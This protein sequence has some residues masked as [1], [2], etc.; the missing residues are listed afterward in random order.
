MDGENKKSSI[1]D[2]FKKNHFNIIF[3]II[4]GVGGYL[5]WSNTKPQ[6]PKSIEELI[7]TIKENAKTVTTQ[8]HS[9]EKTKVEQE[10]KDASPSYYFKPFGISSVDSIKTT[11]ESSKEEEVP[12]C[13][14][15]R[16]D[17]FENALKAVAL[18]SR[19]EAAEDYHKSFSI[20]VAMLALFGIGFPILVA[21]MQH[22]F[23]ERQLNKIEE[24]SKAV[25]ESKKQAD[26]ALGQV[27]DVAKKNENNLKQINSL[28]EKNEKIM[29]DQHND[30]ILINNGL[31]ILFH[32]PVYN[33]SIVWECYFM[34]KTIFHSLE[35]FKFTN[36]KNY[37]QLNYITSF[38]N[39]YLDFFN[40]EDIQ[41]LNQKDDITYM[42]INIQ[43]QLV[44]FIKTLTSIL[45]DLEKEDLKQDINNL[46]NDLKKKKEKIEEIKKQFFK[47]NKQVNLR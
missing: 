33:N 1:I 30:L 45:Q 21:F 18:V 22:H 11:I 39:N 37:T 26:E 13:Y 16:L 14:T 36:P 32:N 44:F 31:S 38:L 35:G 23:N 42:Y 10:F 46:K 34:G 6:E 40:K 20:F 4:F 41:K 7:K 24:T 8:R 43:T 3:A 12:E 29:F 28:L 9:K 15:I 27:N 19:Q 17:D 5:L 47:D 2:W 25:D